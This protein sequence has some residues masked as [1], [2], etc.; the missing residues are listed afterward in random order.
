MNLFPKPANKDVSEETISEQNIPRNEE[1]ECYGCGDVFLSSEITTYKQKQY[2]RACLIVK[3]EEIKHSV[4]VAGMS[5]DEVVSLVKD[6]LAELQPSK[7]GIIFD[8][9]QCQDIAS[10]C[11]TWLS[12][13]KIGVARPN[14]KKGNHV[15]P[16]SNAKRARIQAILTMLEAKNGVI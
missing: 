16:E 3:K 12:A 10:A 9:G 2:C 8:S 4:K 13:N 5:R 1:S 11:R 15:S 7:T 6:L 14:S